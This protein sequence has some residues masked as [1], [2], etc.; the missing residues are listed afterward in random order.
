MG[1]RCLGFCRY[2]PVLPPTMCLDRRQG[3][4]LQIYPAEPTLSCRDISTR[5]MCL[6]VG[7]WDRCKGGAGEEIN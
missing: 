5:H 1:P 3:L 4:I 7:I 6:P 2:A